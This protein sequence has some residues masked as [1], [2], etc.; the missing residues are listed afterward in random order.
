MNNIAATSVISFIADYTK[1]QQGTNRIVSISEGLRKRL[2]NAFAPLTNLRTAATVLGL[3]AVGLAVRRIFSE[4]NNVVSE[5]SQLSA[6]A[7]KADLRLTQWFAIKMAAEEA[8]VNVNS[9]VRVLSQRPPNQS[10]LQF[11]KDISQ[12][13]FVG[14]SQMFGTKA[15]LE[16][17]LVQDEEF[18]RRIEQLLP[19]GTALEKLS[20]SILGLE[21]I[22][23]DLNISIKL[24]KATLVQ[25]LA[26]LL[27]VLINNL[28]GFLNRIAGISPISLGIGGVGVAGLGLLGRFLLGRTRFWADIFEQAGKTVEEREKKKLGKSMFNVSS[29]KEEILN[30]AKD[31]LGYIEIKK[32]TWTVPILS[33]VVGL[34]AQ[35]KKF[36]LSPK[37]RMEVLE[38]VAKPEDFQ[39][40]L[41]SV[42]TA[43]K[44]I[45]IINAVISYG[46]FLGIAG[47]VVGTITTITI[48]FEDTLKKNYSNIYAISKG[49][50]ALSISIIGLVSN[51]FGGILSLIDSLVGG[52][53]RALSWVVKLGGNIRGSRGG[54][55][56]GVLKELGDFGASINRFIGMIGESLSDIPVIGYLGRGL[57]WVSDYFAD[58]A[59]K[60]SIVWGST[61]S[62]L[63]DSLRWFG[64]EAPSSISGEEVKN[65]LRRRRAEEESRQ[66]ESVKDYFSER[67]KIRSAFTGLETIL[68]LFQKNPERFNSIYEDTFGSLINL[69]QI[70]KNSGLEVDTFGAKMEEFRLLFEGINSLV[71]KYPWDMNVIN[72]ADKLREDLWNKILDFTNIKKS[73]S[74]QE[75]ADNIMRLINEGFIGIEDVPYLL[76]MNENLRS[77]ERKSGIIGGFAET[78]GEFQVEFWR[79]QETEE[80]KQTRLLEEINQR[81]R[82]FGLYIGAGGGGGLRLQ[83][84]LVL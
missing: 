53:G 33:R 27:T 61:V 34:F 16:L 26:P 4:V 11:L 25:S 52:L 67:E 55:L 50:S 51:I 5:F 12:Q 20:G 35:F 38:G 59:K 43:K 18:L 68:D 31:I 7:R 66:L 24:L 36:P 56:L 21:P 22:F 63:L 41:R 9:L 82:E 65:E 42:Y 81:L 28:T 77:M 64:V 57:R 83:A 1:F 40:P 23:T 79:N 73:D 8:N 78:L 13:D 84:Q 2:D 37:Q 46:K 49:I 6:E 3:G 19:Q 48:T 74:A 75:I 30:L 17:R 45:D 32:K 10:A 76:G 15:A 62:E 60:F 54:Y 14:L 69:N 71:E 72:L 44:V 70:L 58:Y 80:N 47:T 29:E 39:Y